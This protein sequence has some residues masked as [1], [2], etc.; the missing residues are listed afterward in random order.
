MYYEYLMLR[1]AG[2]CSDEELLEALRKNIQGFEDKPGRLYQTL[3]QA[4]YETWSDGPFGRT[5]DE[6]NKTISYY[7]K[8]PIVGWMFD[9]HIR[10]LTGNKKLLDDV[11]RT[12]YRNTTS[13]SNGDLR[14]RNFRKVCEE[15]RGN[16][17]GRT[18]SLRR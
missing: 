5:G 6:V 7:D 11:M 17:S 2:L 12:L 1:R 15:H 16:Q 4:S 8:G 13:N 18:V 9:L 14:S 10:Y 3:L